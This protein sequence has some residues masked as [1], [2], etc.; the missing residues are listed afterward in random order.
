M[1]IDKM[2]RAIL[3]GRWKSAMAAQTLHLLATAAGI[4]V[5]IGAVALMG[6]RGLVLAAVLVP[7]LDLTVVSPLKWGSAA[8][9]WQ[10]IYRPD[11]TLTSCI[12]AAYRTHYRRAVAWRAGWWLRA[13]GWL[14]VCAL[15]W[16]VGCA[17]SAWLNTLPVISLVQAARTFFAVIT[18]AAL[19][20]GVAA[21]AVCMLAYL[22][23][24][25]LMIAGADAIEAFAWSRKLMKGTYN[26]TVW[27]FGGFAWWL[28][29]CAVAFVP[30]SALFES[31]KAGLAYRRLRD[32]RRN[33]KQASVAADTC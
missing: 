7:M 6:D 13:A 16:A 18:A 2:G 4:A 26:Q 12:R 29:L 10:S 25:Y 20:A 33:E 9:Y 31:G 5:G 19:P 23:A 22:P 1:V 21:F 32:F 30:I 28:P 3:K 24:L 15:P 11:T 17:I 27:Y 8:F 14:S